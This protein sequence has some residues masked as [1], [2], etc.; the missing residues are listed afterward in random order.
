MN[1]FTGQRQIRLVQIVN[2]LTRQR[3]SGWYQRPKDLPVDGKVGL[4]DQLIY[5]YNTKSGSFSG[6]NDFYLAM[7]TVVGLM[8]HRIC[9]NPPP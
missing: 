2:G 5:P 1:D 3:K 8:D 6:S 7:A 4:T 9:P